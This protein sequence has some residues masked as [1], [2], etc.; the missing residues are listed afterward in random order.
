M[1]LQID[2]KHSFKDFFLLKINPLQLLNME[3][4]LA[5]EKKINKKISAEILG[6][7]YMPDNG[8]SIN[9][10]IIQSLERLHEKSHKEF[11]NVNYSGYKI[12][13]GINFFRKEKGNSLYFNVNAFYKNYNYKE[14]YHYTL[15]NSL[16]SYIGNEQ[17]ICLQTLIGQRFTSSNLVL[18]IYLGV[19]IRKQYFKST[20]VDAYDGWNVFLPSP[21]IGFNLGYQF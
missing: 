19:G 15:T 4:R 16:G 8:S 13:C 14:F 17:V 2:S 20:P 5:A 3:L 7:W 11:N 12:G 18:D 10:R 6:S 21:Q 1:N 9:S